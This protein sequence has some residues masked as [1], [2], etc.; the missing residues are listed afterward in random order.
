MAF[1]TMAILA[2]S[3]DNN[4]KTWIRYI[5]RRIKQKKNFLGLIS[6]PTG[7]GKSWCGLS[8][9]SQLD[10]NF[11]AKRIIFNFR[12][13]LKL[14][15]SDE[16]YPAGT[17]FLWDEFQ[18]E[19]GA[20]EWQS[21]TNRLLNSLLSTFRHRNFIL[22]ITSPF[23]DFIDTNARKLLHAELEVKKIDYNKRETKVKPLLMQYNGRKGKTYWKY[24]KVK[25]AKGYPKVT[26]WTIPAPPKWLIEDYEE[27]KMEFTTNLNVS[28][29]KQIER[30][31]VADG[32]KPLTD[33]QQ[34][35]ID[36]MNEFGNV[37]QASA[38][39]GIS[40]RLIYFHLSQAKKKG[41]E[42]TNKGGN[43]R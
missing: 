13:L 31:D 37:E 29:E 24:L 42:P 12:D 4:E 20:R 26:S 34:E 16:K 38:S 1:F 2:T 19:A 7:V 6:G 8:I 9:C 23:A 39:S 43:S 27:M 40:P 33:K 36:L 28:I 17:C 25:T 10:P 14:I 30:F 18:I 15:N 5:K 11:N 32:S 35:C 21:L 41:I 3:S 22:I